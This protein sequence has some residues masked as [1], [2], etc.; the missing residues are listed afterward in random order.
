MNDYI[1]IIDAEKI[2]HIV[3]KNLL[4]EI[5]DS[6][7]GCTIYICGHPIKTSMSWNEALNSFSNSQ[8]DANISKFLHVEQSNNKNQ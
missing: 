7:D 8:A 3:N 4:S 5:V 2:E 1:K 6:K